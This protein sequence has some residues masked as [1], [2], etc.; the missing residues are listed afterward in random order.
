M[1]WEYQEERTVRLWQL[2]KNQISELDLEFYSSDTKRVR[3]DIS[4]S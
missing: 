1:F 2:Y 3:G 4:I